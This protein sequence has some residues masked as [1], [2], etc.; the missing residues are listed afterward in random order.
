M[1]RWLDRVDVALAVA[2]SGLIAVLAIGA[3]ALGTMQ[4]VLRYAFNTGFSWAEAVFVLLTVAAMLVAGSRAVREDAHVR[5]DLLPMLAP[6]R[7]RRL[8]HLLAHL[9]SFALCAWFAYAG[10]QFVGFAH[11][12]ETASP[13]TGFADWV[14]WLVVPITMGMFCVRYLIRI[15]RTLR[16]EDVPPPEVQPP[17]AQPPGSAAP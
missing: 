17:D 14:V 4:V 15:L 10:A 8:L 9:A 3:F 13:D 16:G 5:V 2:E 6:P 11:M 1:K 12:M 7:V